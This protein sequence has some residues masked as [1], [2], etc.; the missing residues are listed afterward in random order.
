M[1]QKKNSEE[2][3]GT[4]FDDVFRTIAQKF[5]FLFILLINKVFGTNYSKSTKCLELRN[6]HY[7][8]DGK[9]ITDSLFCI[10]NIFYHFECQSKKDG[11]MILRMFE[12]DSAIA[13]E[14]AE[15]VN[16]I[17]KVEFPHSCVVYIRNHK[18]MPKTHK[19]E[20]YFPDGQKVIYS[21]P[22]VCV[23]DY[24]VNDLFDEGLIAFLPY[25]VLRYEHFVKSNG[26]NKKK[27]SDL[28]TDMQTIS[29]RLRKYPD[30]S[31]TF[32]LDMIDLIQKINHYIIPEE[33]IAKGKVD[34]IMGGRVLELESERLLREGKAEGRAE[35]RI[36]GRAEGQSLLAK[37]VRLLR[38]G[39][40]EKE[41]LDQ[42]IDK[43]T[44][45]L[46]MT[47]K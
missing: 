8:K 42:G 4:I 20:I 35:G 7:T 11:T 47:L 37:T 21:V 45:D 44:I 5:P 2:I 40:T 33:N 27:M 9:I 14:N 36:E 17:T 10:Q 30:V 28:L 22:I 12:Y 23:S 31:E 18:G 13:I 1:K 15:E 41:L 38:D 6:E 16:G 43:Y 29:S 19:M 24:S 3:S 25:V 26:M 46:A 32:E 39:H 34:E